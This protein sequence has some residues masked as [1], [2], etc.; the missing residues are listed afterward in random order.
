M[1]FKRRDGLWGA[2][3]QKFVD[4]RIPKCP[5][6]KT[7]N[8]HWATDTKQGNPLAFNPAK[9]LMKHLFKCEKCG[10][11]LCISEADINVSTAN[12]DGTGLPNWLAAGV[13]AVESVSEQERDMK[14]GRFGASP[15][16]VTIEEIGNTQTNQSLSGKILPLEEL[17]ALANG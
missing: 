7:D 3:P 11:I 6:C 14:L 16:N 4:E 12:L 15:T 17:N 5:M 10:C 1:A 13:K 9:K 8:P 2:V